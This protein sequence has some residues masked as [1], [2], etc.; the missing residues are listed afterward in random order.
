MKKKKLIFLILIIFIFFIWVWKDYKKIDFSYLNQNKVTYSQ[1]NLNSEF[2]RNTH[3]KVNTLI[4]DTLVKYSLSHKDHWKIEDSEFRKNLPEIKIL[5][6]QNEFTKSLGKN[7]KIYG[8]W[9]KS[10]GNEN[11]IR[12]SNLDLINN[13]NASDLKIAWVFKSK[14]F[15]GAIQANPIAVNGI[16][17]TPISGGFIAAIDG[18]TGQLIWKSKKFGTSVAARGLTYWEGDAEKKIGPRLIFPNRQYLIALDPE[19]G[20]MIESFG[21]NGKIRT[22]LNVLPPV[23]YKNKIIIATWERAFEVYNLYT[24]KVEWKLKYLKDNKKRVG[25]KL[26]NN[27][28]AN[29]WGGMSAD[30]ERGI[31][32]VVTGNPHKYF[33]GTLRPGK[34]LFSNSV[35]AL[36]IE[37]KKIL[38]NFQETSHDIWN[39]DLPAPPIVTSIKKDSKNI[40]V[41]V[42]PTK[43]SNTL[44]LDRLTGEPIYEFKMRRAPVSTVPGEVTSAYQPDLELPEPFGKNIFELDD[45][46]SFDAKEEKFLKEKYSK[47]KF[48]FYEP[49]HLEK[50][51]IQYSFSGGAEWPGASIDSSK[52]IMYITSSNYPTETELIKINKDT[53]ELIPKYKS[54]FTPAKSSSGYPI[55][56]PPWGTLTALNLNTGKIIWQ[57]PFGEYEEL[58]SKGIPL[59]GTENI[60]GATATDGNIV[61]AT[62][63]IDKKFYIFDSTNGN[64]IFSKELP[65]IGSAPPTTYMANNEQY[66]IVHSTG[67]SVLK[68]LYPDLVETGNVL[69]AFKIK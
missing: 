64:T 15:M 56:K 55:S 20:E 62:G 50:K 53:E 32:Y 7:S 1:K 25:G 57:V 40:D 52:G 12:Y 60:G 23:I 63:T 31:V 13:K 43:R 54:K 44:I 45:I 35:I 38:W 2:L 67:G 61:L 5:K 16:V 49:N 18:E 24:G 17:Y 9:F 59:T 47:Y 66:I 34:N 11:A 26:Y 8:N 6:N 46:W 36:D 30:I 28:G 19:S 29:P 37:N 3:N 48:G 22:G 41:I 68:N 51:S 39:S 65:F 10:H 42:A 58:T 4:E 69:V 27:L 21:R 14:N 33:D